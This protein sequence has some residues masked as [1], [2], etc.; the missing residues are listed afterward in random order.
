MSYIDITM[1]G[2]DL[3]TAVVVTLGGSTVTHMAGRP[4][5]GCPSISAVNTQS[6]I[7]NHNGFLDDDVFAIFEANSI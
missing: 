4:E 7:G 3:A 6:I 1:S 2:F 5:T